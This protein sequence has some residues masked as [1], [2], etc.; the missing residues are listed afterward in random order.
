MSIPKFRLTLL[1]PIEPNNKE[2][3]AV[4][5]NLVLLFSH[6]SPRDRNAVR[7]R[8]KITLGVSISDQ[9]SAEKADDKEHCQIE[10][11]LPL[12]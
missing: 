5:G 6:L 3:S 1:N 7:I 11:E 12:L 4:S 8:P 2:N 10:E 9:M